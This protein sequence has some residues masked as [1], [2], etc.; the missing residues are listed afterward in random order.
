M[1]S[2]IVLISGLLATP[3]RAD[4]S[5]PF[6]WRAGPAGGAFGLF[7]EGGATAGQ[8]GFE[9]F[10]AGSLAVG[11]SL[12]WFEASVAGY[13][14]SSFDSAYS[15]GAFLVRL[16]LRF[17]VKYVAF[18][19]G[20]GLGYVEV[21]GHIVSGTWFEP[22]SIGVEVDPVCHLRLGVLGAYAQIY[23]DAPEGAMRGA[24]TVGYVMGKCADPTRRT[25]TARRAGN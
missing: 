5:A 8:F 25:P 18:T 21:P 19:L 22:V 24:L 12:R 1:S 3:A 15:G 14:G 6:W 10:G 11:A 16:A 23:G 20:A 13:L 9:T 7:V 4:D 17:P 2:T